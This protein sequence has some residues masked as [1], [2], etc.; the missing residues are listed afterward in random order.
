MKT[1]VAKRG[2]L[3]AISLLGAISCVTRAAENLSVPA[4]SGA[5]PAS[6]VDLAGTAD[7]GR[8]ALVA[9]D[10]STVTAEVSKDRTASIGRSA[11]EAG[12]QITVAAYYFADYHP[13][14]L[15]NERLKGKGWSEWDLVRAAKPRFAS[16]RQPKV[17]LW[18]YV[19]E[20]NPRVM[21]RKIAAAADHAID[22]FIFD[23]YYYDDGPFLQ[24]ALDDGF[25]QAPN[26]DRLKFA[27]MWANHDWLD[28]HPYKKD[29]PLHLLYPGK[30][31]PETFQKVSD[32]VINN[33]FK[34][35]NYWRIN[36]RP[37]FSFYDLSKLLATFGTVEGTRAALDQFRAKAMAAG[38][39]GV[40][41]NAV[42]WG[43]PVLPGEKPIADVPAL[44][45]DLGFDSVTSYVWV[46]HVP[47]PNLES[48]YDMIRDQYFAYWDQA[49]TQF[50]VPYIPNVTMGWDPSPRADQTDPYGNF[51][52]PFTNTIS[53]N[54]PER[55]RAALRLSKQRIL[56]EG[57]G[58][59]IVNI[60][61]WNEWTEGSYLEPDT[62][63]G[64]QYLDAVQTVFGKE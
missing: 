35:S 58:P 5:L 1:K 64:M 18:G 56:S 44:I 29:S 14:D 36:G 34:R 26:Q 25:L 41:L 60:N 30:V 54:T 31:T 55:F 51:G 45:R 59:R 12:K 23:W 62:V 21:A 63:Y 22:V 49:R 16:H 24:G 13:N 57:G 10:T 11:S 61:C 32:V 46:H 43:Q 39:P 3:F 53:D 4:Y 19:D 2:A 33:Y 15:R 8:P 6:R 27:L 7:Q 38:L 42:V 48:K 52:Y 47:L 20:S 40:H 9:K 17:P 28:I 37:Y 50:S